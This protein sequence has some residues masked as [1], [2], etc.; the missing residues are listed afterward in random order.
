MSLGGTGGESFFV[1]LDEVDH[2]KNPMMAQCRADMR[3]HEQ[4]VRVVVCPLEASEELD[5]RRAGV[6]TMR[7]V[8]GSNRV[9]DEGWT[10]VVVV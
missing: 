1:F 7:R 6:K 2:P 3:Q 5:D 8:R 10:I 4:A 9:S